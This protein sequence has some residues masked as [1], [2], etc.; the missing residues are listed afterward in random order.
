MLMNVREVNT[1]AAK[2]ALTHL[3]LFIAV[4]WLAIPCKE[5]VWCVQVSTCTRAGPHVWFSVCVCL[6]A[7]IAS[8]SFAIRWIDLYFSIHL[9]CRCWWMSDR[10]TQLRPNLHQHTWLFWVQLQTWVF[11]GP[12]QLNMHRSLRACITDSMSMCMCVHAASLCYLLTWIH[13][14]AIGQL[15]IKQSISHWEF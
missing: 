5:M 14:S 7:F 4:V 13:R 15:C 2:P 3:T 10:Q 12:Q 9:V 1:I 8:L 6:C 11:F